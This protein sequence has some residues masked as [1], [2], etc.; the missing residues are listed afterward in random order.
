MSGQDRQEEDGPGCGRGGHL[1]LDAAQWRIGLD[2]I[3]GGSLSSGILEQG[4]LGCQLGTE[5]CTQLLVPAGH[6]TGLRVPSAH[7]P[8]RGAVVFSCCLAASVQV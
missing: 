7:R 5:P 2:W 3:W 6:L 1:C 4:H 8:L